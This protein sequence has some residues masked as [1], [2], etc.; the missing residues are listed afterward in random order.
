MPHD[1]RESGADRRPCYLHHGPAEVLVTY[2]VTLDEAPC[3]S[4]TRAHSSRGWARS[5][6]PCGA[7]GRPPNL[8]RVKLADRAA[9]EVMLTRK[10]SVIIA[11]YTGPRASPMLEE[12]G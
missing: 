6:R 7:S 9:L 10:R 12:P 2:P 5:I 3:A 4:W 11:I 1:T 8:S